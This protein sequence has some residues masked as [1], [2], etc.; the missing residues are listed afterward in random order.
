MRRVFR[1]PIELSGHS[2]RLAVWEPL[3]RIPYGEVK[4][5]GEI[6]HEVGRPRVRRR[7]LWA[8]ACHANR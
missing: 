6:A 3:L 4:T 7:G 1:L 8:G 5:Y 2:F